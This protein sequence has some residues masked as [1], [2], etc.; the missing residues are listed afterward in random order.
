MPRTAAWATRFARAEALVGLSAGT[1]RMEEVEAGV[2]AVVA[3]AAVA[4]AC[5]CWR[6]CLPAA[7]VVVAEPP[8][9]ATS[10]SLTAALLGSM[11][12][13]VGAEQ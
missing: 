1:T 9:A 5:C 13:T 12:A 2:V 7:A 8:A 10:P 11:V 6:S 3:V 4:L